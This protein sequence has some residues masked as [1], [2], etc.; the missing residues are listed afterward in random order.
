MK[1]SSHTA[2]PPFSLG[3]M[4]LMILVLG[5][6]GL[7]WGTMLLAPQHPDASAAQEMDSEVAIEAAKQFLSSQGLFPDGLQVTAL[8]ER[9]VKLL[10][11]LQHT[12][13]RPTTVSFLESE[14]R[15]QIAAY[16]WNIRFDIPPD[17]SDDAFW[18][19]S[20]PL[21][22]VRLAQDGNVSEFRVLDQQTS[23]RSRRFGVPGEHLNR[24]AL[25][26][27]IR[28]D[29]SNDFQAR[30]ALQG[31]ADS[32]LANRLYFN[33]EPVDSV[34]PEDLLNA[35]LT[36]QNAVLDSSY[37]T[38]LIAYHLEN[39]AYAALDW[40]VDSLRVSTISGTRIAVAKLTPDAP[41]A[42]LKVELEIFL[43]STGTMS[44]MTASYKTVQQRKKESGEFIAF[45]A[46]GLY[47]LLGFIFIVVF[48]RRLIGRVLDVKSAMV[49]AMLLGLM[50]GGVTV[51]FTS[52]L[53]TA[54][55]SAPIWGSILLYLLSFSAVAGSVAI[56]GFVV[57]GVSDSIVRETYSG[58]MNTL[59]LLRQGNIRSQAVGASLVRGVA[60][61]GIL[62]GISVLALQLFP[63]LHL[64]LEENQATDLTF[65]P[66]V[67]FVMSG[68]SFS[69][70]QTFLWIVGVGTTMYRWFSG[71][72]LMVA[73]LTITGAFIQVGPFPFEVSYL[74]LAVAGVVSLV[75]A[76]VY[77]RYDII[78]I[79]TAVFVS[80]LFWKMSEGFLISG[81]N[82]WI[83]T[84]LAAIFV[85]S[86]LVLG[87]VGL[88]SDQ[89]GNEVEEYVPEYVTQMAGQERVKRELEIAQEVQSFFL[90]QKMPVIPGLELSGMCL[91][92]TEV[93]GD[94]YD[95][96]ELDDGRMAL[97][98]GDVSGK[99]I[100]AAF[101]MTLVKGITQTL[102]RL[103]TSPAEVMRK[104]NHLFYQNAPNGTFIS[105]IYGVYDPSDRSFVFS[106]A[107][108]NPAI[109]Y[110]A[111][112][113]TASALIP[114][115]MAI[116]F[117]DSSM[118]DSRIAET[119]V[120]LSEGDAM[121]FYTDGFSEA[122]NRARELYGDE[123]L[124]EKVAAIGT[125]S[126]SAILRLV[127]EDVHHFI[128]G[129]GRA[130]DMT[131]V[132]LKQGAS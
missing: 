20:T 5:L 110:Q 127:T 35:L 54:L 123:R 60:V 45:I 126:A 65:R 109:F 7:V 28:A 49:D 112:K 128:E 23:A 42:G 36:N 87:I 44:Q 2:P 40:N 47:G 101:F 57:A 132:V 4:D 78:T 72:V 61:S 125:R 120:Y 66:V 90:P 59:L 83:D 111:K 84:L 92:A 104:L 8:M 19:P 130:D 71:P 124:Q 11:D 17:E 75:L 82:A 122:M 69:Y 24:T 18:T 53:T 41:V 25:S 13:T 33:L 95:F 16:Y 64:T 50:T 34:G 118:F 113:A 55:Q 97:I 98:L 115:G 108:H 10:A 51:L 22:E 27:I 12:L 62:I 38:A 9:D 94:Y 86:L 89:T 131:M 21:F 48:F 80:G 88:M 129:M 67:G 121:V 31:V 43:P 15:N 96:I 56:F 76:L 37:V 91:S 46:A 63:D 100:Q 3:G 30:R 119:T 117:T 1:P 107:G 26:S 114:E 70:F 85:L 52:D 102:S 77:V 105:A 106:R 99:G 93:G 73:V 58:K 74:S 29:T 103:Y 68:F 39:T 6:I 79:L 32:V 14:Y 116:G 81:S